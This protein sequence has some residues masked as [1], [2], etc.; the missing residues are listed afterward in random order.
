MKMLKANSGKTVENFKGSKFKT[1][2]VISFSELDLMEY[3]NSICLQ[4]KNS[5]SL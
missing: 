4:W 3:L 5:L 2:P 1:N